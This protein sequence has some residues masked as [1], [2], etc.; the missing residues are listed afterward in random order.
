MDEDGKPV[1]KSPNALAI[2]WDLRTGEEKKRILVKNLR[3]PE[4]HHR[5]YRNKAT[6]HYLISS[7][8]GAEFLDFQGDDHGQNNWVRGACR[9]GMMPC[10]GMLYVPP[11]QCFCEPGGKLLGFTALKTGPGAALEISPRREAA[12]ERARVRRDPIADRCNAD[13]QPNDG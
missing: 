5:C 13:P 12:G 4:H 1:G 3:S 7:Y 11:D 2:G 10:N 8:E 6:T 9:Y